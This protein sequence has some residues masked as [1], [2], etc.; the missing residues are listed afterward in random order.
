MGL[1]LVGAL[2]AGLGAAGV[3]SGLAAAEALVRSWRTPAL[4]VLGALGGGV[5]GAVAR[6]AA[7]ALVEAIFAVPALDLA[8]GVEGAVIGAAAGLGY[9]L[10]TRRPQGGLA[11]PRG[12][13]RLGVSLATGLACALA[14]A[15]LCASGF[16]LGAA[17]LRSVVSGFP[18][19]QVRFEALAPLLGE[20]H[21]GPRT[22]T[23]LG[24]V[25]GLLFGAGLAA[26]LTRRPRSREASA[27]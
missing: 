4:V 3:G 8:G 5:V 19:T 24:G 20:T 2:M 11:T 18:N 25:E 1:G 26:G 15:L 12:G 6:R 27:S 10:S 13:A 7:D 16:Q 22:R 17:S 23:G 14:G 9:G 21:V